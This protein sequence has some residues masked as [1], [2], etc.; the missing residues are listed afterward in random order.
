MVQKLPSKASSGHDSISNILLKEIIHPLSPVLREIFN[1][2]LSTGEFPAIM[3]L[4]EVIPLY[5][6]KERC[7]ESNY[8]PISLLSTISKILETI[9]YSRVYEFLNRTGQLY[10]N[11]YGFRA[12]HSC[13]HA[14]GQVLGSIIKGLEN[15]F[16]SACVLLDLSKTFDTIEHEI[17]LNKLDLYGIRGTPLAWFRSYLTDQTL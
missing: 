17:L 7:Y 15:N 14:I 3:K 4:A 8:R 6:N 12:K 16:Y 13:E 1:R 11:Q 5:K 9:V 2:S 10:E